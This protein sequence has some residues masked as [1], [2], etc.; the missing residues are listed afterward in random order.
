MNPYDLQQG[1]V[2]QFGK[3]RRQG[4][5]VHV[6]GMI[7]KKEKRVFLF[8]QAV[9]IAKKVK[10]PKGS[11]MNEVF[12]SKMHLRVR[13]CWLHNYYWQLGNL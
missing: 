11:L 9:V 4:D 5:L 12:G 8:E 2:K 3:I 7:T 1:G 10:A 13:P 6:E